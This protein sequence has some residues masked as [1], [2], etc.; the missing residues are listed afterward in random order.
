[1]DPSWQ[2]F[3][4]LAAALMGVLAAWWLRTDPMQAVDA[5][6]QFARRQYFP[7]NQV[8]FRNTRWRRLGLRLSIMVDVCGGPKRGV[9]VIVCT[10][11]GVIRDYFQVRGMRPHC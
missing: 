11:Q 9:Y 2:L 6:L 5:A 3:V 4:G 7:G 1:M 8:R 10:R